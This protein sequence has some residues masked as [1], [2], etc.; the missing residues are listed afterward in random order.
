MVQNKDTIFK[1]IYSTEF[2]LVGKQN[3]YIYALRGDEEKEMVCVKILWILYDLVALEESM[4]DNQYL[5]LKGIKRFEEEGENILNKLVSEKER[6]VPQ[7]ID[8]TMILSYRDRQRLYERRLKLTKALPIIQQEMCQL[9]NEN[10]D[11]ISLYITQKGEFTAGLHMLIDQIDRILRKDNE[12]RQGAGLQV[13]KTPKFYPSGVDL[14]VEMPV[15]IIRKAA[16]EHEEC[17]KSTDDAKKRSQVKHIGIGKTSER[18]DKIP[19]V[20]SEFNRVTPSTSEGSEAS[21]FLKERRCQE[22]IAMAV[23]FQNPRRS[24]QTNEVVI[25]EDAS[26][27]RSTMTQAMNNTETGSNLIKERQQKR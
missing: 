2:Y 16:E 5:R 4:R 6:T 25:Q 17:M 20:T 14:W 10:E 9:E 27:S 21:P 3:D 19:S 8:V 7:D 24:E 22:A 26:S 13:L 23:K 15:D 12:R 1:E 11:K 18:I